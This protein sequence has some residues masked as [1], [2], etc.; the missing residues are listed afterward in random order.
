[1]KQTIA[2][3]LVVLA[4]FFLFACSGGSTSNLDENTSKRI[5]PADALQGYWEANVYGITVS[6]KFSNGSY[7]TKL[8]AVVEG[9][10]IDTGFSYAGSYVINENDNKIALTLQ[11]DNST[12][13]M[14]YSFE[15]EAITYLATIKP[16]DGSE[17]SVLKKVCNLK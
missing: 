9:Q 1:M 3:L 6:Y 4:V 2:I 10:D 12:S 5:T 14:R 13:Y 7:Y 8:A 17:G 16:S 11:E 15:N